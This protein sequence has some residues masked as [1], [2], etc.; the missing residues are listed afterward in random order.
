M[1]ILVATLIDRAK[2]LADKRGDASVPDADWLTFA[3]WAQRSLDRKIAKLDPGFRFSTT[4]FTLTATPAGARFDLAGATWSPVTRFVALHGIDLSPDTVNRRT[5]TRAGFRSR[6]AA[7]GLSRWWT[8]APWAPRIS[9]D[10][11]AKTLVVSPHEGAA[12]SYR[13]YCRGGCRLFTSEADPVA[14]DDQLEDYD[15]WI[16]I[17]MARKGL[18]VEE[19]D[20]GPWIQRLA[21]L[22]Q[23]IED[24]HQRDDGEAPT[25]AD[26]E[27]DDPGYHGHG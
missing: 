8:P 18:G 11:R 21:E 5:V 24:E 17:M 16:V 10:L 12:G 20:E 26:V 1:A 22:S 4:D 14:L 13:A 23:E 6:N 3:N 25:I 9:Y 15:E 7:V 19:S 27:E 2:G